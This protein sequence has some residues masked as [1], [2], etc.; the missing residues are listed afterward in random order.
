MAAGLAESNASYATMGM[1]FINVL[2]TIV[3]LVLVERA[4]RKTL[5]LIGF[6]G[7][8]IDTI[9]LTIAMIF[10]VSIFYM[11]YDLLLFVINLRKFCNF[12]CLKLQ[13]FNKFSSTTNL[14]KFE[15]SCFL[16]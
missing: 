4:G 10:A 13:K 7:M 15:D 14:H 5:L 1:G 8:T 2:M 16:I 6:C 9:L 12:V 3:S 11:F